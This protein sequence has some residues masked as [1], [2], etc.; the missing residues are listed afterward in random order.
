MAA[1]GES[2]LSSRGSGGRGWGRDDLP[3]SA[4]GG[5]AGEDGGETIYPANQ[6]SLTRGGYVSWKDVGHVKMRDKPFASGGQR[7]AYHLFVVNKDDKGTGAASPR[8][9]P[10]NEGSGEYAGHRHLVGKESKFEEEYRHRLKFHT[11]DLALQDKATELAHEF[12]RRLRRVL[13]L[14]PMCPK[15]MTSVSGPARLESGFRPDPVQIAMLSSEIY[16]LQDDKVKGGFRYISAEPYL[17]GSF[18]KYNGNNGYVAQAGAGQ[19]A[20]WLV[21]QAFTHWTFEFTSNETDETLMVCDIQGVDYKY[22]TK[23]LIP[24]LR[25]RLGA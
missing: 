10:R 16:R 5:R 11:I 4:A 19:D 3:G 20:P 9:A 15:F 17:E 21:A 2:G 7:L 22:T 12:N 14:P 8:P 23:L 1:A 13:L 18:V 6:M 25:M 24:D